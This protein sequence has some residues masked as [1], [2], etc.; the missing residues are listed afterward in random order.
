MQKIDSIILDIEI[1]RLDEDYNINKKVCFSRNRLY[2]DRRKHNNHSIDKS[3]KSN[4]CIYTY[5]KYGNNMK[6]Q[7]YQLTF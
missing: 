3:K 4:N 5:Q 7:S 6:P 1:D 2:H